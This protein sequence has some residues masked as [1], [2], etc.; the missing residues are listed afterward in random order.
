M[1]QARIVQGFE[2]RSH[3]H[4][5][6][7]IEFGSSLIE[8]L[9]RL[10][11]QRLSVVCRNVGQANVTFVCVEHEALAHTYPWPQIH[12]YIE[13]AGE[14]GK[15]GLEYFPPELER[16]IYNRPLLGRYARWYSRY[17]GITEFFGEV[18]S[19]A[20]RTEKEILVFDPAN[21]AAFQMLYL[22]IPLATIALG[23]GR[24]CYEVLEKTKGAALFKESMTAGLEFNPR[25]SEKQR[26]RR[27]V[28]QGVVLGTLV[29]AGLEAVSWRIQ[30]TRH[31]HSLQSLYRERSINM[32]DMR[33]VTI[34][35]GLTQY[36]TENDHPIVMLYPPAHMLDG[37]LHYLDHP[38]Q[39][40]RKYRIYSKLLPGITK[41][42]RAYRY[43]GGDWRLVRRE[44]ITVQG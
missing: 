43:E 16:T 21:S 23:V 39:C 34:A 14:H 30:D 19:I 9:I 32:R 28:L 33:W 17:A 40:K 8:R 1:C 2:L 13:Q 42:I 3:S 5:M 38:E 6:P 10:E 25:Q 36:C 31:R 22:H 18:G 20:A 27:T 26:I 11:S 29:V 12:Q 24:G 15:I 7:I 4:I 44:T 41:A 37:V 35:Q